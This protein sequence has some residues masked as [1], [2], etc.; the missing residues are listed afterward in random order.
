MNVVFPCGVVMPQ[1]SEA[2]L[3]CEPRYPHSNTLQST[4]ESE[5]APFS[6]G[7]TGKYVSLDPPSKIVR[8]GVYLVFRCARFAVGMAQNCEKLD[9][10]LVD[11][12]TLTTTLDHGRNREIHI[13]W[14]TYKNG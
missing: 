8:R 1:K 4:P 3:P 12:A 9:D 14:S 2:H 6:G 7:V 13:R 11:F 10:S 5:Y